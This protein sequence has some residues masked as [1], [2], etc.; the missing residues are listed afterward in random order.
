M[1]ELSLKE[2]L[3]NREVVA[4]IERHKWFESEKVGYDIGFESAADDWFK[5]FS[6]AWVAHNMPD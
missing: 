3:K 6:S 1:G 4:E 2:L 5:R